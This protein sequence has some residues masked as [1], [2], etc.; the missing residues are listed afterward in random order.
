MSIPSAAFLLFHL[1]RGFLKQ[2]LEVAEDEGKSKG[3]YNPREAYKSCGHILGG[4]FELVHRQHKMSLP[5]RGCHF[6]LYLL[7]LI[8]YKHPA[9]PQMA[10]RM[11]LKMSAKD[12][13]HRGIHKQSKIF[14]G[15]NFCHSS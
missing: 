7:A 12:K 15:P 1:Y 4:Q 11:A 14:K 6:V 5:H 8:F 3:I 10:L 2:L 13:Q 9:G